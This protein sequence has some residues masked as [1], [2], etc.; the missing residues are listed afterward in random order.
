MAGALSVVESPTAF[1]EGDHTLNAI[2]KATSKG[3]QKKGK[4][5]KAAVAKHGDKGV[6]RLRRHSH[7]S[8][9]LTGLQE[10]KGAE[11]LATAHRHTVSTK[12]SS[13]SAE[14]SRQKL[15]V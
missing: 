3:K 14:Q 13:G 5:R 4:R 6:E 8:A 1:T 2:D 12:V 9:V 7:V 10:Y 15:C 11:R